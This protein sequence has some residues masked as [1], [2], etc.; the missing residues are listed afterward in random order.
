M[1]GADAG[2]GYLIIDSRNFF[3]MRNMLLAAALIGIEYTLRAHPPVRGVTPIP[4]APR[5]PGVGP[6]ALM[7]HITVAVD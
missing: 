6:R 2:L 7:D 4:M 3:K 5:R 1:V